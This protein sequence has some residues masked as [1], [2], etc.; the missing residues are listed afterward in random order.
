MSDDK[1][2]RAIR[3]A[4]LG[5]IDGAIVGAI[6]FV[7]GWG[8]IGDPASSI[9]SDGG[10][11]RRFNLV[12]EALGKVA[13]VGA[14]IGAIVGAIRGGIFCFIGGAIGDDRDRP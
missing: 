6:V 3:A 10:H 1:R 8:I 4:I 14:S 13:P 7:L 11:F 12:F 2:K 5:A 9:F